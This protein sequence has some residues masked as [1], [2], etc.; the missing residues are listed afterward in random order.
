MGSF[1][2]SYYE[3]SQ[4]YG[5]AYMGRPNYNNTNNNKIPPEEE[6]YSYM[7]ITA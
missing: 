5:S 7:I 4:N 3:F 2:I 1:F 6:V